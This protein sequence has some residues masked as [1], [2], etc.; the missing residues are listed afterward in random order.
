MQYFGLLGHEDVKL[1]SKDLL[2]EA[3][4]KARR[5]FK[6][7][8]TENTDYRRRWVNAGASL[9]IGMPYLNQRG[10]KKSTRASTNSK[11]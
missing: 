9:S 1:E 11:V 10:A 3:K 4:D 2:T 7:Y 5:L 6:N 8:E